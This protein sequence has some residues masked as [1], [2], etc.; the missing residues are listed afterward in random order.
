[1][2]FPQKIGVWVS[3]AESDIHLHRNIPKNT[4]ANFL[5]KHT[6]L[7]GWGIKE[8]ETMPHEEQL[9]D[10]SW[11]K[12]RFGLLKDVEWESWLKWLCVIHIDRVL[13]ASLLEGR[14]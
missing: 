3:M 7:S 1:M 6:I 11:Q 12:M 4:G 13:A 2:D 10:V 14:T 5:H 9:T 8:F